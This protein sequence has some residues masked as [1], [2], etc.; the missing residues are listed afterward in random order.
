[1]LGRTI[2]CENLFENG[3]EKRNVDIENRAFKDEWTKGYFFVK[4]N[5]KS[6]CLICMDTI[7]VVKVNNIKR[8]YNSKHALQFDTLQREE[9]V[10]KACDFKK[11]LSSQQSIFVKMDSASENRTKASYVVSQITAKRIKPFML[12]SV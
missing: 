12:R 11:K 3:W 7:A 6:L 2:Y 4:N 1:L 9:R 10:Q 5:G 8:H